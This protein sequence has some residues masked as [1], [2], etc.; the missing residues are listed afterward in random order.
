MPKEEK[1]KVAEL[2]KE[3]VKDF[4]ELPASERAVSAFCT[5]ECF[6]IEPGHSADEL[7]FG[8]SCQALDERLAEHRRQSEIEMKE[9]LESI[10]PEMIIE[11]NKYRRQKRKAGKRTPK[12]TLLR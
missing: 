2:S 4:R 5:H 9:Y 11:E 7:V 8:Q 6:A 3:L 10:T 1:T 12:Y